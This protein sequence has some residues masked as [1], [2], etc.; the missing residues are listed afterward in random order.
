MRAPRSANSRMVAVPMTPA[1]PVHDGDPAVE[2]NSIGH[3]W[4][5]LCSSGC[6]GFWRFPRQSGRPRANGSRLFHLRHRLTS[7][8]RQGP[9]RPF[10][11]VFGVLTGG[12]ASGG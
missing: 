4:G 2:A 6:P 12:H 1:A 10:P 8:R 3:V 7:G 9:N 5:F 11:A